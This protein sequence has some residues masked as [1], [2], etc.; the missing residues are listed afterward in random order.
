MESNAG[1]ILMQPRPIARRVLADFAEEVHRSSPPTRPRRLSPGRWMWRT[2]A[3]H[4][5]RSYRGGG[6]SVADADSLE[7]GLGWQ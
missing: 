4:R 5:K 6:G 7:K 2:A 1:L 3:G